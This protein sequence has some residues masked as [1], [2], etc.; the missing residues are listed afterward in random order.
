MVEQVRAE[1]LAV[2]V[3]QNALDIMAGF[4]QAECHLCKYTPAWANRWWGPSQNGHRI[5]IFR[6]CTRP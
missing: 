5:C 1:G 3:Q 4:T 2:V 6:I